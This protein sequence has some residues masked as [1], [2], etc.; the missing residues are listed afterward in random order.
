MLLISCLLMVTLL[1]WIQYRLV[2]NTY[3]LNA[4]SYFAEVTG[5]LNT[6]AQPFADSANHRATKALIQ[7]VTCCIN[8]KNRNVFI[9]SLSRVVSFAN[10]G[11]QQR[12]AMLLDSAFG[13]PPVKFTMQYSAI[14]LAVDGVKDTLL[15]NT[16]PPFVILGEPATED[17]LNVGDGLQTNSFTGKD[18]GMA[19]QKQMY[20]LTVSYSKKADIS[21][22]QQQ[23][24][25]RMAG[26]FLIAGVLILGTVILFY[27]MFRTLLHQKKIA[28]VQTD[29]TN[30]IT[31]ELRTPLSSLAI[32]I[33]SL[34]KASVA[35]QPAVINELMTSME[36]QHGK[37]CHIVDRVLESAWVTD[38]PLRIKPHEMNS[39]VRQVTADF[40]M[41]NHP[42][43]LDIALNPVW[44]NMDEYVLASIIHNILDNAVKYSDAG[45]QVEVKTWQEKGQYVIAIKDRG[46][47]IAVSEQLKVFDKFY[48]VAEKNLHT[49]K[50][51]GLG[52]YLCMVNAKRLNGSLS[53][54]SELLKGSTFTIR[55]ALP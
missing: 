18:L 1:C 16:Q 27:V 24:G 53:V 15:K 22:W 38:A 55:F 4:R 35:E 29:L 47:G 30:N 10:S 9:D 25:Q 19:E 32:I 34:R 37:L 40:P 26:T 50:G 13:D 17:Q 20:T 52:L 51:I 39:L 48:R 7:H 33:K 43:V 5:K 8:N 44:I 3:D 21:G 23:V 14:V 45:T 46:K 6:L 36:R 31:H 28:D 49:V 11:D 54:E 2:R 12:L 41:E 42:L